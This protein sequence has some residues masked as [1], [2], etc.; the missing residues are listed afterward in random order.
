MVRSELFAH[1][2]I[3]RCIYAA[4]ITKPRFVRNRTRTGFF[5][6]RQAANEPSHASRFLRRMHMAV[7]P[8]MH[9]FSRPLPF[10]QYD[11]AAVVPMQP[12]PDQS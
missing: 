10:N 9:A 5:H 11:G 7:P 3:A 4:V 2:G 1:I 6:S 12:V 8:A